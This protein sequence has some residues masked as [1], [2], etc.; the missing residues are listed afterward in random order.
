[1]EHDSGWLRVLLVFGTVV[2]AGAITWL[3]VAELQYKRK[4]R[5]RELFPFVE[6]TEPY[7]DD[8]GIARTRKYEGNCVIE[9]ITYIVIMTAIM[10]T[11]GAVLGIF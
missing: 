5:I 11:F 7:T 9:A 6:V 3:K 10:Y 4:N 1:M 2:G 8:C